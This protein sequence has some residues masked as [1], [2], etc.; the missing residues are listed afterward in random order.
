MN[1][2]VT[3][4]YAIFG[5]AAITAVA[6]AV[7][8]A[9]NADHNTD[10]H[11]IRFDGLRRFIT[12]TSSSTKSRSIS[13][14]E[15][16]NMMQDQ[17]Q[18]QQQQTQT[19]TQHRPRPFV[20]F[21]FQLRRK[22]RPYQHSHQYP[23]P[24]QHYHYGTTNNSSSS[25]NSNNNNSSS[26]NS[27]KRHPRTKFQFRNGGVEQH[28]KHHY[29]DKQQ[30][31]RQITNPWT[32][33]RTMSMIS[34]SSSMMNNNNNNGGSGGGGGRKRLPVILQQIVR[35]SGRY[36]RS[37]V[38]TIPI[39]S[40]MPLSSTTTK[41]AVV[42][43]GSAAVVGAAIAMNKIRKNEPFRRALY[44]WSHIGPIVIHYKFTKW[45]FEHWYTDATLSHRNAV[46]DKL[47]TQYA[48][49]SYHT[50]THL[51]GLYIKLIQVCSSRPDFI[52]YQY[53]TLFVQAQDALEQLPIEDIT[54]IIT[55]S[56][57]K[58]NLSNANN[59]VANTTTNTT[60][61]GLSYDTVFVDIEA[62]ALGSASIG[63]CHKATI[64]RRYLVR[65]TNDHDTDTDQVDT[66]D[67]ATLIDVAVKVMHPGSQQRFQY[68]YQVF[69]S[70][71]RVAL[72]GWSTILDELYRQI[73]SEFDYQTEAQNLHDV[74]T[75][76][77]TAT[78]SRTTNSGSR[79]FTKLVAIPKPY[80]HLC[81]KEVLIMELLDG[82]KLSDYLEHQLSS[83]LFQND[84][85]KTKQFLQQKQLELV[86]GSE[87]LSSLQQQQRT[88]L[89]LQI[90]DD[91]NDDHDT[92]SNNNDTIQQQQQ[93]QQQYHSSTREILQSVGWKT[94]LRLWKLYRT[95]QH[96]IDTVV[97]VQGYQMLI[98]GKF[99]G[100][101][102]PG[103]LQEGNIS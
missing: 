19:Q 24:R 6:V 47:H 67:T 82:V 68:D 92:I 87:K 38:R 15:I 1:M 22:R 74:R 17:Q 16:V 98:H 34:F 61:T 77:C 96:T 78:G 48:P 21:P 2:I 51:K 55:N 95:A 62:K 23:R 35:E 28:H 91:D 63:Q 60:A 7:S 44:F 102:H 39:L 33:I 93:Q 29:K 70:L 14:D 11:R 75:Q 12:S 86:L 89:P 100:D 5:V 71:C 49:I 50:A 20:R 59:P 32:A 45:Y 103:T 73:M 84:P 66:D 90:V 10:Y 101:P 85:I 80:Q 79:D 58:A 26:S 53:I 56:Y 27:S 41:S 99:Q 72:T 13:N 69:R 40:T 36:V 94:K 57:T 54:N 64:Q 8:A 81:T 83:I 42:V 46:Y 97:D 88:M 25:S 9:T 43:T 52:P 76:T 65:N 18:Q 30:E 31:R 4:Y 37:F 3:Y